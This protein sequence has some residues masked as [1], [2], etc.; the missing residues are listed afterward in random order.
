MNKTERN[1]LIIELRDRGYKFQQ[2][3]D[4]LNIT[5]QR[6]NKIYKREMTKTE[7]IKAF[8]RQLVEGITEE[9]VEQEAHKLEVMLRSQE[10]WK[11]KIV[12]K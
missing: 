7:I 1:K 9:Q 8:I 12:K 4:I 2:I 3:A 10:D 5:K 11:D 6:V